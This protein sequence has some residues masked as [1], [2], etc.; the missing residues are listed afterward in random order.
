MMSNSSLPPRGVFIPTQMIFNTQLSPAVLVTWIKL[1]CL[2]WQSWATP[3]LSLPELASLVGIHPNRLSRQLS[4]LQDISALTLRTHGHDKI[5]LS[6]PE[7]PIA[8]PEN[9][10]PGGNH[11]DSKKQNSLDIESTDL[12]SYFPRRIM[13]YLTYDNDGEDYSPFDESG[14]L[15]SIKLE[16]ENCLLSS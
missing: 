11:A 10:S 6:F 13:G 3:P 2:A 1:R 4:A 12:H 15:E 14:I 7:D 5:V 9:G 8:M 16:A